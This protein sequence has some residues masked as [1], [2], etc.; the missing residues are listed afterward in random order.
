MSITDGHLVEHNSTHQKGRVRAV[1]F[2]PAID[3]FFF[4]V[5]VVNPDKKSAKYSTWRFEYVERIFE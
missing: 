2:D 1:G 5:E 4:L 3:M